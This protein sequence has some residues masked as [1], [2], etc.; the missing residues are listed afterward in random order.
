ML[1]QHGCLRMPASRR[2]LDVA[3]VDRVDGRRVREHNFRSNLDLGSFILHTKMLPCRG[4]PL[5]A[6]S[7]R[8]PTSRTCTSTSTSTRLTKS[9]SPAKIFNRLVLDIYTNNL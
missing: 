2:R 8:A 3:D 7:S 9:A 1:V 5:T 4:F 6:A